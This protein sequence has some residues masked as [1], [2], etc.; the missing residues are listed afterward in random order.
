MRKYPRGPHCGPLIRPADCDSSCPTKISPGR[1]S[2]E[3]EYREIG[4]IR[5]CE[6]ETKLYSWCLIPSGWCFE[7]T[8]PDKLSH[9]GTVANYRVLLQQFIP[10]T[11]FQYQICCLFGHRMRF[12]CLFIYCY[13]LILFS[14]HFLCD[15][16]NY[17]SSKVGL[18]QRILL[19]QVTEK[20]R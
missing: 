12:V 8:E 7:L 2:H 4:P 13:L 20:W 6:K 9:Y 3:F 15:R 1:P 17:V 16:C 11:D 10:T 14:E 19:A 5:I 18:L